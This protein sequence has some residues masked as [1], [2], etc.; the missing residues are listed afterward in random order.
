MRFG[1]ATLLTHGSM[2]GNLFSNT[3]D[4][5]QDWVYS[6]QAIYSGSPLGTLKLQVS[7]DNVPSLQQYSGADVQPVV[8]NW[9]DYT[10]SL[11]S[12]SV[13]VGTTSFLWNCLYPGYRWVRVAYVASSGFGDLTVQFF[14]KGN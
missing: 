8:V 5:Q 12:T 13:V 14:G 7:T 3:I 11:S 2:S 4:L 1:T 6:L 9:T 10:G